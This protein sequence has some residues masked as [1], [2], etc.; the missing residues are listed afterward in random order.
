MRFLQNRR[1]TWHAGS[2]T[3]FNTHEIAVM[4]GL[5][6]ADRL[7]APYPFSHDKLATQQF[8]TYLKLAHGL[9]ARRRPA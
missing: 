4:S 3:L 7:G 2:V 5:A 8:D 6:V 1:H 9:F